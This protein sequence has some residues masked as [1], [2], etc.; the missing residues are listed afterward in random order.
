MAS[1]SEYQLPGFDSFSMPVDASKLTHYQILGVRHDAT[2]DEITKAYRKKARL[3]HPDKT[4]NDTSEDWMK[5]INNA[6]S[7]LLSE[8][9]EDYD[10]KL[11]DDGQAIVDPAGYLPVGMNIKL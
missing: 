4:G 6:K 5:Q 8:K 1:N 9:R 11:A 10:E 7:T 3:Y 2:K